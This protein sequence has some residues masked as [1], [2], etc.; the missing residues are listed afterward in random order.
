MLSA[1]HIYAVCYLFVLFA[2]SGCATTLAVTAQ[3]DQ[4]TAV[5]CNLD[6]GQAVAGVIS[7]L[8]SGLYGA[9]PAA[10][11]PLFAPDTIQELFLNSD[12]SGVT[13][14]CPTRTSLRVQGT[15]ASPSRQKTV[16]NGT[17]NASNF[18]TC[19]PH[20]LTLVLS[21]QALRGITEGL[22]GD[23]QSYLDLLMAPL[24]T[25][26]EMTAAE[27][28]ELI[29]AVYG[30]ELARELEAATVTIT[31]AAPKGS[32]IKETASFGVTER[33]VSATRAQ[34]TLPL[35]DFLALQD[36][37]SLSIVW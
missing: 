23:M 33:S 17:L 22:S 21:P 37:R 29:E 12:F 24:F 36:S 16:I 19:T 18:I 6:L 1:K 32:R 35:L 2:F 27:Y 31:A 4:S 25:G 15:L 7:S 8:S 5:E 20:S 28:S 9:E 11:Q 14:V 13:A 26:E 3:P 30:S 10:D 34:F